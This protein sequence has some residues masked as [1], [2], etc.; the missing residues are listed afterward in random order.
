MFIDFYGL[1]EQPFG[2]TPNPRYFYPSA[3]HREALASLIYAVENNVGFSSLIAEP[4]MGKTS[5]LFSLLDKFSDSAR[6]AFLFNTQCQSRD[7]LRYLLAELEVPGFEQDPVILHEKFKQVVLDEARARRRVIVVI[8]EAQNLE[9]DALETVRLLSN[10]ESPETKLLH[11]ILAGQPQLAE[12][13]GQPGLG[14]LRQRISIFG[15]LAPFTS[16]ESKSYIEHRLRVAGHM[17]SPIF[18][19]EASELIATNARGVP[20]N[21]NRICFNAMSLGYALRKK[22]IDVDVVHEVCA[23]L[24]LS[25]F[26]PERQPTFGEVPKSQPRAEAPVKAS[27]ITSYAPE[28][29]TSA[30]AANGHKVIPE[31][32]S[33]NDVAV[34]VL[35]GSSR[36]TKEATSPL[37][38]EAGKSD[39]SRELSRSTHVVWPTHSAAIRPAQRANLSRP[40]LSL[41]PRIQLAVMIL[42]VALI[43]GWAMLSIFPNLFVLRKVEAKWFPKITEVS[44]QGVGDNRPASSSSDQNK[45]QIPAPSSNIDHGPRS[46]ALPTFEKQKSALVA[47]ESPILIIPSIQSALNF[48]GPSLL[49]SR[50]FNHGKRTFDNENAPALVLTS[51][52]ASKFVGD[53]LQS[54][55][56]LV[57][58]QITPAEVISR[59]VPVYPKGARNFRIEGVVEVAVLIGEDG[60]VKNARAISGNPV[61]A[62]AAVAAI[63]QWRYKPFLENGKPAETTT[64]IAVKFFFPR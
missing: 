56:K 26:L 43:L 51:E 25:S 14:Q 31:F 7:L 23:D 10:F 59:V 39:E 38:A 53:P 64:H 57:Q 55:V 58:H 15:R 9:D 11:I 30:A 50:L 34:G 28:M 20:R 46:E 32:R 41:H 48:K 35:K 52:A 29:S 40:A 54:S 61:L 47:T 17:G 8:D 5:L 27:Q 16:A 33:T 24:D 18:A 37:P 36:A 12:K 22:L 6:T 44:K 1:R 21:I 2:V 60:K 42:V 13:L 62:E 4:G 45:D 49:S 19:L 63:Q 3:M